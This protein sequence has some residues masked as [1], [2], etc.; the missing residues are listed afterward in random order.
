M[1]ANNLGSPDCG[2]YAHTRTGSAAERGYTRVSV[3]VEPIPLQFL[4]GCARARGTRSGKKGYGPFIRRERALP[5]SYYGSSIL[6]E[7]T[8]LYLSSR[9]CYVLP[10]LP[11]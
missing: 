5:K 10:A 7:G 2:D 1:R 9:P 4:N 3:T 8:S 11:T 6:M